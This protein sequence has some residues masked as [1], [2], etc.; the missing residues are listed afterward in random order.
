[1]R[2]GNLMV[3]SRVC[4]KRVQV[5][6]HMHKCIHTCTPMRKCTY[7]YTQK[8]IN[9]HMHKLTPIGIHMHKCIHILTMKMYMLNNEMG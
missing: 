4:W 6:T 5:Y 8:Y 1:M 9:S 2:L 3:L 7:T